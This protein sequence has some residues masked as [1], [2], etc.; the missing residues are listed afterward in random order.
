MEKSDTPGILITALVIVIIVLYRKLTKERK[1]KDVLQKE[2]SKLQADNALI[3]A[4]KLKFQL[5]PH[6]LNNLLAN[7]MAISSKLNR[8]M[9][10]LSEILEYIIYKGNAHFV[11]GEDE[12]T[13][14]KKYI[15]LNELRTNEIDS[16]VLDLKEVDKSSVKY[17]DRCLPHLISAYLIENAYKH[18]DVNARDFLDIK[19]VLNNTCYKIEVKNRLRAQPNAEKGGV[20]LMN[21][22][23][24]LDLLMEGRYE[25]RN[26]CNE[27]IYF[28]SLTIN[29]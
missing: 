10:A 6:T 19:V 27:N 11:S 18:G 14:I 12:V 25:Y 5:E 13:F 4:E 7:L 21:M 20:G 23:K 2:N 16:V 9:E 3:E 17:S 22:Q 15:R 28:T 29:F 26:S 24:R 1:V 8:G